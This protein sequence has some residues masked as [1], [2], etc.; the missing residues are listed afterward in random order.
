MTKL[1][2]L[3][4]LSV[5]VVSGCGG[6]REGNRMSSSREI[7]TA[8]ELAKTSALNVYDAIRMRRPAFLTPRAARSL[9]A[10]GRST[11]LPAV[12][13]NGIYHGEVESLREILILD[14]KE[15]RYLDAKE[16]TLMYGS[17]HVAGVISVTTKI[18]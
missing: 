4:G 17:G 3:L 1:I 5:L 18:N 6:S 13:L 7:L 2:V 10:A 12:Y 8:D 9:D 11:A 14:V 16:S 15:V